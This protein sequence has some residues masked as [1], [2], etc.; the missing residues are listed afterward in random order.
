MNNIWTVALRE[1]VTRLRKPSFYLTTL[2]MPLL[3]G[4]MVFALSAFN[5]DAAPQV[6]ADVLA[7]EP[8]QPSGYVDQ[9]EIITSV[10]FELHQ[11]FIPYASETDAAAAVRNGAIGSYFVVPPDYLASGH[12]AKVSQQATFTGAS[13]ADVRVFEALLRANLAGDPALGQ[14]IDRPLDLET[15]IVGAAQTQNSRDDGQDFNPTSIVLGFLLLFAIINGGG[16]LVQAVVEEKENRTIE[17]MLTS[18]RPLHLMTGKLLGLGAIAL[19]QLLFWII[20]SGGLLGIAAAVGVSLLTGVPISTW[21]WMIAFFFLGFAFYGAIMMALGAVGASMREV[22]QISGFMTVP[23]LSPLWFWQAIA[24]S[25]NGVL[26]QVLSYIPFTAPLTMMLRIGETS[27]P[28]WQI[29]LSLAVLALA[30]AGAIWV[31]ARIFRS[32]TLLTG[33]KPTPRALWR[34]VRRA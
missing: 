10:P 30:V 31:A 2:L 22:G 17:V 29:L 6:G 8:A 20:M 4:V 9:A 32:S 19:L 23:I 15:E 16:W 33:A 26:A 18:V 11:F 12:V 14:R 5:I 13:G 24:Q 27:V 34:A 1:I 25:P 21:L 7:E 28:V 3:V